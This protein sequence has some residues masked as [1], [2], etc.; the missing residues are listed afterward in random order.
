MMGHWIPKS[1][2]S[3]YTSMRACASTPGSCAGNEIVQCFQ[4]WREAFRETFARSMTAPESDDANDVFHA[5]AVSE[6]EEAIPFDA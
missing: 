5:K 2:L 4:D 3:P 1:Q 6:P